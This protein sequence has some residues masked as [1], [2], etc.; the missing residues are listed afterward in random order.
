M[1]FA[2]SLHLYFSHAGEDG[3]FQILLFKRKE[4]K[5]PSAAT[6]DGEPAFSIAARAVWPVSCRVTAVLL[7]LGSANIIDV[8][9]RAATEP[10]VAA[11]QIFSNKNGAL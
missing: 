6:W 8:V 4:R 3:V 11:L 2:F 9:K 1:N 5:R 10:S 7:Y